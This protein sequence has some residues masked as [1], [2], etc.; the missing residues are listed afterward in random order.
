MSFYKNL[1]QYLPEVEQPKHKLS[2]K[3]KIYWTLGIL[4]LF[5]FLSVIP[6]FGIPHEQTSRFEALELILGAKFGK[7]LTL[8]IGPIVTASIILQLLMGAG[9]L[10]FDNSTEEGKALY[11]GTYKLLSIFMILF[12]SFIYVK[13][14]AITA[15]EG[16]F[17]VVFFQLVMGGL[18][19]LFM[20]EVVKNWGI[21]SGISLFIAA[22]VAQT[23]FI[24]TL[25]PLTSSGE[26]GFPITDEEPVGKIFAALYYLS[27]GNVQQL[28]LASLIPIA[29][30][31]GL[32]FLITYFQSISVDLPLSFGRVRG[33]TIKW[34]LNF[35]YTSNIPVILIAALGAN[36]QLW[37]RLLQNAAEKSSNIIL[38]F[39]SEHILGQFEGQSPIS[40]LVYWIQ[41][42]H[43]FDNLSNLLYAIPHILSYALFMIVGSVIF[44][45]FWVQTAGLDPKSQ[46]KNIVKSG[47]KIPGFRSDQRA[48]EMLLK[49]Y[50]TPLTIMGGVSVGCLAAIADTMGALS[51]G[52]G[53]LLLIMI[54]HQFYQILARES[55]E[56]F[57]LL[58]RFLKK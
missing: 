5:Y 24:Q 31:V 7:L 50:I 58:Q 33:H 19:V 22:G 1:L 26:I 56:D 20:D 43:L 46:A 52:T 9:I 15:L 53:I 48:I 57:S 3:T 40:G 6:L 21:G 17:W 4:V 13:M 55:L 44:G 2:L 36:F 30:T 11:T 23:I 12:E 35:F 42:V 38:G 34:P 8:G 54:I 28:F 37:A 18:I 25:S 29:V 16:Y 10:K 41:P 39:I 47:L 45:I 49:K 27:T 14:G 32:F 51:S